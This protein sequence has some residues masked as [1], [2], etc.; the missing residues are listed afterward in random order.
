MTDI[1]NRPLTDAQLDAIAALDVNLGNE[2]SMNTS[3]TAELRRRL[4]D[5]E[6]RAM[7][8]VAAEDVAQFAFET[9]KRRADYAEAALR[10]L[11]VEHVLMPNVPERLEN[12]VE[13]LA[14]CLIDDIATGTALDELDVDGHIASWLEDQR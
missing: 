2:A 1:A 8:A 7:N 3:E 9:A 11:L 4:A 10:A 5:A 12:S 13:G 14:D 6:L